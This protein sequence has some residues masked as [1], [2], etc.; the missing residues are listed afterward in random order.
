MT[1]S[2]KKRTL[3]RKALERKL[4]KPKSS[5]NDDIKKGLRL[6]SRMKL[7]RAGKKSK[8]KKLKKLKFFFT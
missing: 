1:N 8:T 4:K 3:K 6:I 7:N 2:E 5:P